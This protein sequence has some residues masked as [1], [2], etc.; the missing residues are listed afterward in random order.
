V[1]G[2]WLPEPICLATHKIQSDYG[3]F[4]ILLIQSHGVTE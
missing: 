1:E 3:F 4:K 2:C